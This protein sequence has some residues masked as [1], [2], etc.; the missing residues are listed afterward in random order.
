MNVASWPI[1]EDEDVSVTGQAIHVDV[2]VVAVEQISKWHGSLLSLRFEQMR[3][4]ERFL[5]AHMISY[6]AP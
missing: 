6:T 3:I 4:K 5:D 2:F 1:N